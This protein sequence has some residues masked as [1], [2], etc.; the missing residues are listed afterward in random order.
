MPGRGPS[1]DLV[2]GPGGG[3]EGRMT[4]MVVFAE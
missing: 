4:T 2:T 1:L 3:P